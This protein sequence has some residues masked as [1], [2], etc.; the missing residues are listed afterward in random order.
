M[1]ELPLII[2]GVCFLLAAEF[3]WSPRIDITR[4]GD[5]MLWYNTNH[6]CRVG[7]KLF[8]LK[9]NNNEPPECPCL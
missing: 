5:V 9:R 4:K 3:R 7:K 1:K 2:A 6:F 8:N